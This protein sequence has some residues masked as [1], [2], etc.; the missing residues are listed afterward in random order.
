MTMGF[1]SPI[2]LVIKKERSDGPTHVSTP[3]HKAALVHKL[4]ALEQLAHDL[5]GRLLGD[6]GGSSPWSAAGLPAD[7]IPWW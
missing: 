7:S 6:G 5:G 1:S 4:F 2:D 3:V